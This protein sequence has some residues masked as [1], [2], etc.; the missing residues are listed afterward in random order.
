M[1]LFTA[2]HTAYDKIPDYISIKEIILE[3]HGHV[4]SKLHCVPD[5]NVVKDD[6]DHLEGW[7]MLMMYLLEVNLI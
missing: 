4:Q 2:Y 5:S 3:K 1:N 6:N 7:P